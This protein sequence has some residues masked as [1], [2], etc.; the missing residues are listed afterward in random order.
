MDS[1]GRGGRPSAG[2]G[3]P[4]PAPVDQR[5]RTDTVALVPP[6]FRAVAAATARRT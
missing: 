2:A 4:E 6:A 1:T 3:P 5:T